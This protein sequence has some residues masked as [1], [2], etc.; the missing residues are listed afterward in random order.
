MTKR[1]GSKLGQGDAAQGN[2]EA[3][4]G[5]DREGKPGE[6]GRGEAG[7]SGQPTRPLP[8]KRLAPGRSK[9][10]S[11]VQCPSC[12]C[13]VSLPY[14]DQTGEHRQAYSY[15]REGDGVV[16]YEAGPVTQCS[17]CALTYTITAE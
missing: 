3:M 15:V 4:E 11:V 13:Q 8:L 16:A 1:A 2:V 6:T 12:G 10:P 5:H 9:P 7:Q 17:R 14:L